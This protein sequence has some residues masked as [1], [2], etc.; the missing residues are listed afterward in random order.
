MP[1]QRNII[2]AIAEMELISENLTKYLNALIR[3]MIKGEKDALI[4]ISPNV[5]GERIF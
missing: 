1:I 5:S 3:L 2:Y 4:K